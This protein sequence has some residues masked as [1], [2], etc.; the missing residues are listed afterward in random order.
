MQSCGSVLDTVKLCT[1]LFFTQQ[2]SPMRALSEQQMCVF[3]CRDSTSEKCEKTHVSQF[4]MFLRET[5]KI[6]RQQKGGWK[7]ICNTF[8]FQ[9]CLASQV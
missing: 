7:N 4:T 3:K 2:V 9:S 8:W 6:S 1:V 5:K